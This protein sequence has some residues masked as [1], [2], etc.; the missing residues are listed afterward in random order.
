MISGLRGTEFSSSIGPVFPGSADAV[1][2]LGGGVTAGGQPRPATVLRAR[3]AITLYRSG[4][5]RSIIMSGAYGTR[6]G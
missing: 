1:L 2:A 4:R 3:H 6:G 5:A